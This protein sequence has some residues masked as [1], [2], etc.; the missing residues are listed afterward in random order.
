MNESVKIELGNAS[1]YQLYNL[2]EDISQTN[3][4]AAT[5]PEKLKEMID[6]FQKIR[7][8]AQGDVEKLELK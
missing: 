1:D 4:L 6:S 3:N 5:N 2:K 8:D 7:G